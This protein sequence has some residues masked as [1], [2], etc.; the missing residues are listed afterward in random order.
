MVEFVAGANSGALGFKGGVVLLVGPTEPKGVELPDVEAKDEVEKNEPLAP[1][2]M[3]VG[4]V[5]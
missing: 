4:A 3:D 5:N 2:N 1:P